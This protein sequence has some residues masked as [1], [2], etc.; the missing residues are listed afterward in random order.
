SQVGQPGKILLFAAQAKKLEVGVAD[1]VTLVTETE[2]GVTNSADFEVAAVVEDM[3]MMSAW[4]AFISKRTLI[5]LYRISP[6]STGAVMIY[7]QDIAQTDA[8]LARLQKVL[9][10]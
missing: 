7:L 5:D 9:P 8:V 3:G 6:E 4:S 2:R 10:E 1:R